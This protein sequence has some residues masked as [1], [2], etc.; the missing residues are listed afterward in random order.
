MRYEV[1]EP[2]RSRT[3]GARVARLGRGR[4]RPSLYLGLLIA[5]H[6]AA[7]F[8]E[9]APSPVPASAVGAEVR[10]AETTAVKPAAG[11]LKAISVTASR[12]VADDPS[13]ATVGK[14]PLALRE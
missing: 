11:E 4:W 5:A 14:M 3:K 12:G 2:G 1:L 7:A 13:V 9:T 8:A 10:K 6:P